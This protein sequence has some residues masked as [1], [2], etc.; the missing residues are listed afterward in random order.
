[1]RLNACECRSEH[2]SRVRRSMW[3]RALFPARRLYHCLGCNEILFIKP[4][5]D[6][7]APFGDTAPQLQLAEDQGT[8]RSAA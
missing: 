7:T 3:M 6:E 5:P 1:M 4:V 8:R 2:Y